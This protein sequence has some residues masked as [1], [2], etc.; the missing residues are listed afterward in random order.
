MKRYD[1]V[2]VGGGLVG[3]G[4]A[5]ALRHA[6]MTLALIDARLPSS[7]DPRLFALNASSCQFLANIGVWPQLISHASP[8]HQVHVSHRGRFGAVRLNREDVSA[9]TL[10]HVIP[11]HF[12]ETALNDLL[13]SQANITLYRPATLKT[14]MQHNG[15]ATLALQSEDTEEMIEANW[16]IGADGADSSVRQQTN[17]QAT[18]TDY[19]QSALV[20]RT[21]LSRSHHH[22]AY[23]RFTDDGAIAMLP[24]VGKES[25]TIWTAN[26][27]TISELMSLS[28]EDFLLRLQQEFGYRLGRLNKISHRHVFPL[29]MV[30]AEKAIEG[31]V[32]LLGNAAHTL[33]PIAAQGFNL[34]LYEVAALVQGIIDKTDL[35]K[36]IESVQKQQTTSINV[37][38]YLPQVFSQETKW[39]NLFSSVGMVGFDLATPLKKRFMTSMMGRAGTVP[40]LLLG[41]NE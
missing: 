31:N 35:T 26:K 15:V 2:I 5:A 24:L 30:R 20:T 6:N 28:D 10:G 36:V 3:A 16:V 1:F 12:I 19:V 21:T 23:E 9:D 32:L 25:A 40:P 13:L 33:H 27:E 38:H 4:L 22:I 29:R 37:S 14:L 41:M 34:A 8:I 7:N 17:I 18:V 11:A 39:L